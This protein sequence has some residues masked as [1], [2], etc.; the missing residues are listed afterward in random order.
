[1]AAEFGSVV[2]DFKGRG[3]APRRSANEKRAPA[4]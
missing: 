4:L 1:M 2:H 3:N